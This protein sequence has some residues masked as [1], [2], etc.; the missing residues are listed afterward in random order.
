M[1]N[2]KFLKSDGITEKT[3]FNLGEIRPS[4]DYEEKFAIQNNTQANIYN[5]KL[6]FFPGLKDRTFENITGIPLAA[7]TVINMTDQGVLQKTDVLETSTEGVL[8]KITGYLGQA[9]I[10]TDG[11]PTDNITEDSPIIFPYQNNKKLLIGTDNLYFALKFTSSWG[12]SYSLVSVKYSSDN[13]GNFTALPG[14]AS[15]GTANFSQSGIYFFGD[16]R[17]LAKKT[18]LNN[19][20]DGFT[21]KMYWFEFTFVLPIEGSQYASQGTLEFEWIYET[22]NPLHVDQGAYYQKSDDPTPVY[23]P[24]TPEAI[25]SN[26]GI[27]AFQADPLGGN[28][29]YFIAAAYSHKNPPPGEYIIDFTATEVT[30]N[31]GTPSSYSIGETRTDLIPGVSITLSNVINNG[32]QAKITISEAAKYLEFAED[33][34]GS[35]GTYKNEDFNAGTLSAE[36]VKYLWVRMRPPVGIALDKNEQA[37]NPFAYHTTTV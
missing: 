21:R 6:A 26:Q 12:G 8:S 27:V 32:D 9:Y 20:P 17:G 7:A 29:G 3:L 13:E 37:F 30:V 28:P 1:G 4:G 23:T 31:S 18:I 10:V 33:V 24:I 36:E 19:A 34:A 25:Y 2:I 15:D 22:P 5:T 35:P 14:D 16:L 11:I